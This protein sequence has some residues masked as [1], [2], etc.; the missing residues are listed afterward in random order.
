[1]DRGFTPQAEFDDTL[2]TVSDLRYG[3]RDYDPEDTLR[4]YA[5]RMHEAGLVK[6]DPKMIIAEGCD[7]RFLSE[8]KAELRT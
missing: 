6:A 7:W 2:R 3:R 4:F 8:L 5:L 1:V